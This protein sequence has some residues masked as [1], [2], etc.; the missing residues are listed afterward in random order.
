MFVPEW[1]CSPFDVCEHSRTREQPADLHS[2]LPSQSHARSPLRE[3]LGDLAVV[4]PSTKAHSEQQ[5]VNVNVR[6]E[7]HYET[8]ILKV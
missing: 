3:T 5:T 2:S 1:P 7:Q 6:Q 8:F 4:L